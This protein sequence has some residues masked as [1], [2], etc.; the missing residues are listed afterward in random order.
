MT[1]SAVLGLREGCQL[2]H[3]PFPG[4]HCPVRS[5]GLGQMGVLVLRSRLL[6]YV[7]IGEGE[8]QTPG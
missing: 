1:S 6:T 3:T 8:L 4:L 5:P 2:F 7:C